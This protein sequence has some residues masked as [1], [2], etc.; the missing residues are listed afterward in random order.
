MRCDRRPEAV[1]V[2][3]HGDGN[4]EQESHVFVAMERKGLGRFVEHE[5]YGTRPIAEAALH[6][7]GVHQVSRDGD[8]D[9]SRV[10]AMVSS[11]ASNAPPAPVPSPLLDVHDTK[12]GIPGR[13]GRAGRAARIVLL[14]QLLV[15]GLLPDAALVFPK[16]DLTNSADL[17]AA[18]DPGRVHIPRLE[19][20]V[21]VSAR[22]LGKLKMAMGCLG[23]VKVPSP[24]R[25]YDGIHAHNVHEVSLPL[26]VPHVVHGS[27]PTL[28]AA[29]MA[30]PLHEDARR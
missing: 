6:P 19:G 25:E 18:S 11:R 15:N 12:H 2:S 10:G 20:R 5:G 28:N 14:Y 22:G 21:G 1:W 27:G 16:E 13:A 8:L 9:V 3:V 17:E 23:V 26:R 4:V 24:P 30:R 7:D 29:V